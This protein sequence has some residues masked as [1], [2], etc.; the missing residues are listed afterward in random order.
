MKINLMKMEIGIETK[1]RESV[2]K[3]VHEFDSLILV[4]EVPVQVQSK[5]ME[6]KSGIF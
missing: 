4:G 6:F 1:D 2:L 3:I 5:Y